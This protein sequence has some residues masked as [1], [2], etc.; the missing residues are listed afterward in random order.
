MRIKLPT[1][2]NT[3]EGTAK[4]LFYSEL[5]PLNTTQVFLVENV[6]SIVASLRLLMNTSV[7][8]RFFNPELGANLE[9]YLFEL[10]DSTTEEEVKSILL[11]SITKWEPRVSVDSTK[12][13]II[14]D[15]DAH[16]FS[17]NLVF[18]IK[19]SSELYNFNVDLV[20]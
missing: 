6:G 19:G 3:V 15:R 14:A 8:E 18:N 17:V 9:G 2:Y 1:K 20:A 13:T 5:N 16:K 7:G 12:T 4:K 10:M 11:E